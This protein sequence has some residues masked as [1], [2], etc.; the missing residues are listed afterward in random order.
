MIHNDI[1]SLR[2]GMA[3]LVSNDAPEIPPC[4][5]TIVGQEL[6]REVDNAVPLLG[7]N[8]SRQESRNLP[9]GFN[10]V[11]RVTPTTSVWVG[12]TR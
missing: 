3:I 11:L 2:P 1:T 7:A 9:V 6:N 10:E 4:S 8:A 12:V 5:R